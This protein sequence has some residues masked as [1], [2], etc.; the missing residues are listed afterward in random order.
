MSTHLHH[1]ASWFAKE[2]YMF[3]KWSV[4]TWA[5]PQFS[6]IFH[7]PPTKTWLHK[8]P[9]KKKQEDSS[10]TLTTVNVVRKGGSLL[11]FLSKHSWSATPLTH[12][13]IKWHLIVWAPNAGRLWGQGSTVG[14]AEKAF[15]IYRSNYWWVLSLETAG[16]WAWQREW[17][18][19]LI[20]ALF[21]PTSLWHQYSIIAPCPRGADRLLL[22]H[23]CSM[24][25]H[26]YAQSIKS[27]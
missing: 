15:W 2:I 23:M 5:W 13:F 16:I 8:E 24:H 9:S 21:S 3:L 1:Q 27:W 25:L 10:C 18:Q 12:L 19:N 7:Q 20:I 11:G 4:H 6:V 14:H 17:E 22:L 26:V